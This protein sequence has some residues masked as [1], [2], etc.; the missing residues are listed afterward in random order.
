MLGKA[1]VAHRNSQNLRSAMLARSTRNAVFFTGLKND[2]LFESSLINYSSVGHFERQEC[3]NL[4]LMLT[5]WSQHALVQRVGMF[6]LVA[7]H[8]ELDTLHAE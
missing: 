1:I 4:S 5:T 7:I 8:F 2:T 3:R 6:T